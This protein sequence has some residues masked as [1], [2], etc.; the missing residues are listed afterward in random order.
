M[1]VDF[2]TIKNALE[3]KFEMLEHRGNLIQIEDVNILDHSY[4]A[5]INS[6]HKSC[7]SLAQFKS[8]SQKLILIIGH[9]S[10]L[11]SA[12]QNLHYNLGYYISAL[13]IDTVITIGKEAKWIS[14][15]IKKINHTKKQIINCFDND[16]L[17]DKTFHQIEP[18]STLLFIGSKSL[19]LADVI[20]NLTAKVKSYQE[21]VIPNS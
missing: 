20:E 17:V 15:G 1:D 16:E 12:A 9:I 19:K 6:V 18:R 21:S 7:E 2:V 5:T 10:N 11:E 3:T 13:P 14:D 4:N 8:Y